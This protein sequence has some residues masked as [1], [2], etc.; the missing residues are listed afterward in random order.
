LPSNGK[1]RIGV[2]WPDSKQEKGR[3]NESAHNAL[4]A[5]FDAV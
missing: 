2:S 4:C 5:R 1:P 3:A